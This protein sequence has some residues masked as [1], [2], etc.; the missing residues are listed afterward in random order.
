M[1]RDR[2]ATR[3]RLLAAA[4]QLIARDGVAAARIT[5]IADLAGVDKVLIYRYFGGRA[6]LLRALVSERRLWPSGDE[7]KQELDPARD[8]TGS[9]AGD[10]TAMLL[11][12]ARHLRAH[13]LSRRAAVWE[14]GEHDEFAREFAAARDERTRAIIATLR[15]RHQE[16]LPRFVDLEA[17]VA[18]LTAAV[19]QLA[20]RSG[21]GSTFAGLDLRRA[22]DWRR[23]ERALANSV[24][25]LLGGTDG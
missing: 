3:A 24:H 7:N 21:A 19:T 14:L 9:L 20:L 2:H 10:L 8:A 25:A 4:E 12:T 18:L 17:V 5:A 1:P 15:A 22:E 13:P 11:A 6:Q 23:V 16:R